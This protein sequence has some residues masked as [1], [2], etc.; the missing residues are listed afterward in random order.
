VWAA[1]R[2]GRPDLLETVAADS[3]PLV[4]RELDAAGCRPAP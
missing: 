1:A 2:L 3:D 4:I